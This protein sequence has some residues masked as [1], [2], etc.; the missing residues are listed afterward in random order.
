MGRSFDSHP[1][2][3][4]YGTSC[5][6]APEF[7]YCRHNSCS[8]ELC[9]AEPMQIQGN[10]AVCGRWFFTV[11]WNCKGNGG[12]PILSLAR[13]SGLLFAVRAHRHQPVMVSVGIRH[14]MRTSL[15][16]KPVAAQSPNIRGFCVARLSTLFE[17]FSLTDVHKAVYI[18]VQLYLQQ[19]V[20]S[21][22][23]MDGL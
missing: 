13:S 11:M 4:G 20:Y 9:R 8:V 3:E 19:E 17:K 21:P 16:L 10:P 14:P 15:L 1:L 18:A 23:R 12:F 7:H 6:G 22:S 5:R 2:V